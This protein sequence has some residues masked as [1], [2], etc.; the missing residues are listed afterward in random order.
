MAAELARTGATVATGDDWLEVTPARVRRPAVIATYDDHR[1]A[2]ALSLAAL[3][4]SDPVE[5]VPALRIL[6][7]ATVGKT[8]P[9]YWEALFSVA[10]T[11]TAAIPVIAIDGPTASGKGTLANAVAERLGYRLLDSGA[12]YRA[13][14]V[15]ALDGRISP[16]DADALER[17]AAGLAPRLA[18]ADGRTRLDGTDIT[19]RLRDESVGSLASRISAI[20]GVRVALLGVQLAFRRVPGLVADGRDMGTGRLSRRRAQDLLTA[21]PAERA[22]RRHRQLLARGA[23]TTLASLRAELEARDERDRSRA[24][25]PLRPAE[26]A[27]LLDNSGLDVDTSVDRVLE[28]WEARRPFA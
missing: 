24:A 22:T 16:D 5:R 1:M 25:S 21:G 7:P 20:P 10:A 12:V 19:D 18:F 8:Y 23:S 26:D 2:M 15:A 17:L 13:A 27:I 14:A 6:D 3:A 4:G 28:A 9:G 11:P